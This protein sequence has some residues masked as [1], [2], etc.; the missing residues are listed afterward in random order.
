LYSKKYVPDLGKALDDWFDPVKTI[1][2]ERSRWRIVIDS[3]YKGVPGI[4]T[5]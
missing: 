1:M 5:M 4:K 3:D 2:D